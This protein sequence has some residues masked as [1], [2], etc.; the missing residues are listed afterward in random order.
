MDLLPVPHRGVMVAQKR[1]LLVRPPVPLVLHG[2]GH[3]LFLF[4]SSLIIL[5][6]LLTVG[7]I[8]EDAVIRLIT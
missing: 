7:G 1:I 6:L 4:A 5:M 3:L 8:I 2:M